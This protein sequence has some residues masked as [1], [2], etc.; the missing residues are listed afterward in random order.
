MQLSSATAEEG[1]PLP[2]GRDVVRLL[3]DD[4]FGLLAQSAPFIVD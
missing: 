2:P 1:W 4:G 3:L